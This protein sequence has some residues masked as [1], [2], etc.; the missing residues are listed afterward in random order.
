MYPLNFDSFGESLMTSFTML[1]VRKYPV[2]LE[3]TIACYGPMGWPM[4]Y[5]FSF[6]IIVVCFLLNVFVAFILAVFN[7]VESV[8]RLDDEYNRQQM[9]EQRELRHLKQEHHPHNNGNDEDRRRRGSSFARR[10]N[11]RTRTVSALYRTVSGEKNESVFTSED[12]NARDSFVQQHAAVTPR[13]SARKTP[14]ERSYSGYNAHHSNTDGLHR[15]RGSV[16][17]RGKVQDLLLRNEDPYRHK[18]ST[19]QGNSTNNVSKDLSTSS[20]D[21]IHNMFNEKAT[22]EN[23]TPSRIILKSSG[24]RARDVEKLMLKRHKASNSGSSQGSFMSVDDMIHNK[25]ESDVNKRQD[26]I[27]QLHAIAAALGVSVH[28]ITVSENGG[29]ASGGGSSPSNGGGRRGRR[30]RRDGRSGGGGSGGS[31]GNLSSRSVGFARQSGD[32]GLKSSRSIM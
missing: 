31:G 23:D 26:T 12:T 19:S 6:Y 27:K 11:E 15:S 14:R 1:L 8:Q 16:Y 25:F 4:V 30:G 22:V 9:I 24:P 20:L 21:M 17:L 3:G 28:S 5:Y 29:G 13:N 7:E 10:N 18:N 32:R 2:L